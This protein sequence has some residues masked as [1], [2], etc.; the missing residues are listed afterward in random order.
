MSLGDSIRR[1]ALWLFVGNT[2]SQVLTF[3]FGIILARLLTP[4]DFGMLVT[5]QVFTG[6]AGF[7]AGG[8]MGQALVRASEATKQDYDIVFTLQLA[9]GCAIYAVF[10]FAAPWFASWYDTPLY[11]NLLRVSALSFIIRPFVNLPGSV[12]HREMRYKAQAAVRITT[13]VVSS[14]VSIGMAYREQ[15]VW[16]LIIGG[17]AGSMCSMAMLIRLSGWR[18]GF[19]LDIRRGRKVARYGLLVSINDIVTYLRNQATNFLL[20]RTLGAAPVGLFNK[21][22]S[23]A[24]MPHGMITGPVYQVL[25]RA[26]AKEQANWDKSRYLFFRSLSLVAVYVTPLYVGVYWTAE[27]MIA[28][29]YGAKWAEAAAPLAILALAGPFLTIANLSGCVLAA[30]NQ[31]GRELVVQLIVLALTVAATLAGLRYGLRGIAGALVLV[32]IYNALHMYRLA[33]QCLN[34]TWKQLPVSMLPAATLNAILASV[35]FVL[36]H[37]MPGTV[38]DNNPAYLAVVMVTGALTYALCF[39]YLPIA[40]LGSEQ[41]RWKQKLRLVSSTVP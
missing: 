28:L 36:D 38:R 40:S 24:R 22:D 16:S 39:L 19:S 23:L 21:A 34:A 18:P 20:G 35:L 4:E 31:L 5:I 25:F 29:L 26:L 6:L 2:G 13:L 17:F 11:A 32:T 3:A 27:P 15:G 8:G 7:V 30:R 37:Y 9:I 10:Y 1:G 41:H 12:L 33:S 14:T